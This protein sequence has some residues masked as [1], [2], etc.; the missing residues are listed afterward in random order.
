MD[1]SCFAALRANGSLPLRMTR[2]S[3]VFIAC[4]SEGSEA[5][6]DSYLR[7]FAA[8]RM[9][10]Q[11]QAERLF[12]QAF[13]FLQEAGRDGAV[14]G[15]VVAGERDL[16]A[17]AYHYLPI[18]HDGRG[19]DRSDGQDGRF[20]RVNDGG[21]AL[22]VVHAQVAD[23]EGAAAQVIGLKLA[24]T[25]CLGQ[26]PRLARNVEDAALIGVLDD[27]N[28]QARLQ[29][30]RHADIDLFFLDQPILG[31][32]DIDLRHAYQRARD[33]LDN[34]VVEA[35]LN[36]LRFARGILIDLPAQLGQLAGIDDAGHVEVRGCLHALA[37]PL[38]N[39]APHRGQRNL[40]YL[41][42][43]NRGGNRLKRGRGRG[44][45]GRSGSGYSSLLRQSS[46]DIHLDDAPVGAGAAYL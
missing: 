26:P 36:R 23:G 19:S 30:H 43:F 21:E 39:R 40:H 13:D 1:V 41:F 4:H 8:L 22:H 7:C 17:V 42:A 29:R 3:Y 16:H 9:T 5:S 27:G 18:F 24:R 20:G 34:Q 12:Q 44:W 33:G 37:Q 6:Q 2:R 35:D 25:R 11:Q 10:L 31:E 14:N 28:D 45:H 15:A 46:L 32:G 38:R